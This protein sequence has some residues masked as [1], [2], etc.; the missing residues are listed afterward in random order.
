MSNEWERAEAPP[1]PLF[2]NEKERDFSKQISDE[3]VERVVGQNVL[4]YP[5]SVEHT[6]F[7]S[8]YGEAI[9][10]TYL[11]PVHVY[12][13]VE[14]EGHKTETTD[15]GVDRRSSIKIHF[16]E[17]RITEDQ[18]LYVRVGDVVVYGKNYYEIVELN[19]PRLFFGQV[20]YKISIEAT[21]IRIRKGGFNIT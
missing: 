21:C 2:T 8:L 17:R 13:M 16:H 18:D 4:Y 3:V 9:Y 1:P 19:E 10:K 14:W 11:P 5:I 20:Q 15:L 6:N 12:A 7:H